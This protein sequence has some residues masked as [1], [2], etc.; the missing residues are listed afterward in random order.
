[1]T[2]PGQRLRKRFTALPQVTPPPSLGERIGRAHRS[3]LRRLRAGAIAAALAVACVAIVPA[4][5]REPMRATPGV[6]STPA[7]D[8]EKLADVRAL[9][10]ALQTAYERNASD[11]EIAP[12]WAARARLLGRPIHPDDI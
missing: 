12:L 6:A 3:R 10:R 7:I 8:R 4:L 2:T 5:Q 9:D 11:D 1:M